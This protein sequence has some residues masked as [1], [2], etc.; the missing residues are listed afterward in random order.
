[1]ILNN[2]K[3]HIVFIVIICLAFLLTPNKSYSCAKNAVKIEHTSCSEKKQA[4][5]AKKTDSCPTD[6]SSNKDHDDCNHK[7]CNHASCHCAAS[8]SSVF[9]T[10]P[11]EINLREF[12]FF[13]K[14]KF[15][16][17]ENDYFSE[18]SSLWL[19]PKIA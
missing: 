4:T 18:F 1:M 7:D 11:F 17:K 16:F 8:F 13:T 9:L 10:I 2:L 12:Y 15:G 6:S 3:S 5:S 14:Q 19:P